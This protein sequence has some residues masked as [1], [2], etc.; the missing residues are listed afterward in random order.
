MI[1]T[2]TFG[3]YGCSVRYAGWL[4]RWCKKLLYS[5][6]IWSRVF[7]NEQGIARSEGSRSLFAGVYIS[8]LVLFPTLGPLFLVIVCM[9]AIKYSALAGVRRIAL[10]VRAQLTFGLEKLVISYLSEELFLISGDIRFIRPSKQSF[11]DESDE[12]ILRSV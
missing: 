4:I 12:V 2:D 11:I 10:I 5:K 1:F 7:V 8:F 6:L 9:S 3:S